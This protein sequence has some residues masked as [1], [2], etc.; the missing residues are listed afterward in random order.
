[1]PTGEDGVH[2]DQRDQDPKGQQRQREGVEHDI[3]GAEQQAEA[4]DGRDAPG[5]H[6]TGKCLGE[7]AGHQPESDD[8]GGTENHGDAHRRAGF[9]RLGR[10]LGA[11]SGEEPDAVGLDEGEQ[12]EAD[13][14]G[15][16]AHRDRDHDGQ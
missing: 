3:D 14:E 8:E 5:R 16:D 10:G 9:V 1:V 13:G 7:R 2:R 12:S 15:D 4:V 11:R 6:R